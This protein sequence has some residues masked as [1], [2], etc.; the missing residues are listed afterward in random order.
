MS[1]SSEPHPYALPGVQT[2]IG[3]R[4][5]VAHACISAFAD[6]PEAGTRYADIR[7]AGSL[8]AQVLLDRGMDLGQVW[9]QGHPLAWTS[10]TGPVHPSYG[11]DQNWLQ[12]F[13][14]G[15]MTGVGLENVGLPCEIDETAYGLHGRLSMTAARNVHLEIPADDPDAL[16][17]IGVIRERVVHGVDLELTRRYRFSTRE[18]S[19]LIED[20][21]RNLG[22]APA[23]IMMLYHVN[24]GYP[25]VDE[26]ARIV[27]PLHDALPFNQESKPGL[28]DHLR[29]TEP[30]SDA[31]AEVFE[32]MFP[33]GSADEIS[34]GVMNDAFR[35]TRGLGVVVTY[36]RT[37]LPR[38]YEW[39]MM[40]QGRYL[41][42]IEPSTCGLEGRREALA[43][44]R[45]TFLPP[46]GI[47]AC[48]LRIDVHAGFSQPLAESD[49][50]EPG[51]REKS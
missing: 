49:G 28:E 35:P 45:T 14:G 40:G 15:L 44:G 27:A 9:Y 29:V 13:H 46:G 12:L 1:R 7:M 3:D 30:S 26:G 2:R 50:L 41:V 51:S 24:I 11:N 19:I 21:L 38:L 48:S 43:S 36:S 10:G 32:L 5:Q 33:E 42:G 18:A 25:V 47:H 6:G 23:P 20:R 17:V 37:V 22:F 16:D 8:H 34:V 31:A 39:R 4:S